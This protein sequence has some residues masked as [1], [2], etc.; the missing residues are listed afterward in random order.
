[1]PRLP[2]APVTASRMKRGSRVAVVNRRWGAAATASRIKSGSRAAVV[3]RRRG[4]A[5]AIN[6]IKPGSHAA[7]V[8]RR[9]SAAVVVSRVRRG[10]RAAI[11]NRRRGT[12][13][14][15]ICSAGDNCGTPPSVG[16]G[17]TAPKLNPIAGN[18]GT[19][20]WHPAV[21]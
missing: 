10:S 12:T 20:P 21:G 9:R 5:V 19:P 2:P 14:T 3:H 18:R 15:A 13:G 16:Y 8:N 17:S 4:P 1:M 11:V 7:V 6:R